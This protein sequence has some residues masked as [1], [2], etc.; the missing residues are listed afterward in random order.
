MSNRCSSQ[1]CLGLAVAGPTIRSGCGRRAWPL[2][3]PLPPRANA[4]SVS[5]QCG[6]QDSGPVSDLPVKDNAR[7]R[8]DSPDPRD[9]AFALLY[10]QAGLAQLMLT[11]VLG[12]SLP[13]AWVA[14]DTGDSS[15]GHSRE[16]RSWL[17]ERSLHPSCGVIR[18]AIWFV[19]QTTESSQPFWTKNQ[20]YDLLRPCIGRESS[21]Q[22]IRPANGN[23][24]ALPMRVTC[25]PTRCQRRTGHSARGVI[26]PCNG[27]SPK[28]GISSPFGPA[29]FHRFTL[30]VRQGLRPASQQG[31][32]CGHQPLTDLESYR[33]GSSRAEAGCTNPPS[34][35]I[36]SQ[37]ESEKALSHAR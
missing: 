9:F 36:P 12:A 3:H 37:P 7:D 20:L 21:L 19:C 14:D 31:T 5:G 2:T 22:S 15:H 30:V 27:I 28:P 10:H 13:M 34:A 17:E 23:I 26:K 32:M 33:E 6:G 4:K 35:P 1:Y 11:H 25:M 24:L 16:L 8:P 18:L 29:G